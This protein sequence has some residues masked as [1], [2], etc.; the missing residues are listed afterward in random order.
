MSYT[1]SQ[2]SMFPMM[3]MMFAMQR[4]YLET[5]T[6]T[7]QLPIIATQS[8][9]GIFSN[10][11]GRSSEH[12]DEAVIG[13]GEETLDVS[14]RRIEGARTRIRRV[15]H[16][17]PVER[18]L[19]LQDETV[20][21]E[22]RE[23]RKDAAPQDVLTESDYELVDT[24]EIPVVRKGVRLLEEVVLRKEK[25]G[26]IEMIRDTLRKSE[27][28]VEQPNRTQMVLAQPKPPAEHDKKPAEHDKKQQQRG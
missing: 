24:K 6:Q 26:R 10:A 12:F 17:M 11:N 14:T 21:V 20:V 18:R 2:V 16:T 4:A 25:T 9:A 1:R 27:A 13:I 28:K 23:V 7:T 15:V 22:R 3:D 19:E 8:F 5:L